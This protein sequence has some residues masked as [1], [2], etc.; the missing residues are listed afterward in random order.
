M[1]LVAAMLLMDLL[2]I[3][4]EFCRCKFDAF[5]VIGDQAKRFF[6]QSGLPTQTLGRIWLVTNLC[7]YC[8]VSVIIRKMICKF[9]Y[10]AV[11]C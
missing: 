8:T 9:V 4:D 7:V 10:I 5:V 3:S 11:S 6:L 2:I 1:A